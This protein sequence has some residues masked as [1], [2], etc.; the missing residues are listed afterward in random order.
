MSGAVE[1][2]LP[3]GCIT[4]LVFYRFRRDL[5]ELISLER[6]Q[7]RPAARLTDLIPVRDRRRVWQELRRRGYRIPALGLPPGLRL[8]GA[9]SVLARSA[10]LAWLFHNAVFMIAIVPFAV[11]T[12]WVTRP[13]AVH[14]PENCDTVRKLIIHATPFRRQ[15]HEAGLWCHADISAK[16][17]MT[18]AET[19]GLRFEDVR[20]DSR[21][22]DL[23]G[24]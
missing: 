3:N 13:F 20:E 17:R 22:V 15:D 6:E 12:Y 1:D 18:I 5:Q 23:C 2:D 4:S 9:I 14:P 24:C 11:M 19:I 21:I 10:F 8:V 7:I 16:V